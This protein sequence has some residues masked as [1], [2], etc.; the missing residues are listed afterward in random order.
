MISRAG[1]KLWGVWSDVHFP[2]HDPGFW[3]ASRL[4]I[5]DKKPHGVVLDGD[6]MDFPGISRF[7]PE[8]DSEVHVKD[9]LE[10][11]AAELR[12]ISEHCDRVVFISGN[13]E[14]RWSKSIKGDRKREFAGIRT[15]G[16]RAALLDEGMPES[17]EWHAQDKNW[18]SFQVANFDINHGHCT[19]PRGGPV[20]AAYN[21]LAG[22]RAGYHRSR[23]VGHI[24]HPDMYVFG[25]GPDRLPKVAISNGHGA[26]GVNYD[27]EADGIKWAHSFLALEVDPKREWANPRIVLVPQ[28]RFIDGGKVYDGNPEPTRDSHSV[29]LSER[30]RSQQRGP[31]G[32][33][34]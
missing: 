7:A 10:F 15:L 11:F 28:G 3:E 4:W 26:L 32:R 24:H 9:T 30:A 13:H 27:P 18:H 5:A 19:Y 2:Y 29:H 33:F 17:V 1:V 22:R 23:V 8:E 31:G 6:M 21:L 20:H 34:A 16:L 14:D 12:W 25:C